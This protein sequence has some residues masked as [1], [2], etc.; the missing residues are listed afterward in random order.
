MPP[1]SAMRS[2]T[3]KFLLRRS[4]RFGPGTFAM[5]PFTRNYAKSISCSLLFKKLLLI[6]IFTADWIVL[7]LLEIDRDDGITSTGTICSVP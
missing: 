3:A 7:L 6:W 2:A 4:D 1:M 5:L